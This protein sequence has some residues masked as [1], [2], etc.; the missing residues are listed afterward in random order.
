MTSKNRKGNQR[1]FAKLVQ[2]GDVRTA[3]RVVKARDE[4]IVLK[5][6]DITA[7]KGKRTKVLEQ[8]KGKHS[9]ASRVQRG[10]VDTSSAYPA[11]EDI[12]IT[13]AQ[14]E[15]T[16]RK[17]LG[18]A[19]PSGADSDHWKSLLLRFGSQS[20][21]LRDCIATLACKMSNEVLPWKKLRALMSCRLIALDKRPGIRPM[22]V[23]ECLRRLLAKSI[24][25]C[26]KGTYLSTWKQASKELYTPFRI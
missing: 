23:G 11:V 7:C 5:A 20:E 3:T 6:N 15:K 1:R 14:I 4:G 25:D 24:S 8:L 19:G 9:V 22:G 17:L 18:S 12:V 13:F 16:A 2:Q 26:T 21:M 10:T